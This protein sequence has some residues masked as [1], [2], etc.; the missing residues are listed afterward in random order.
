MLHCIITHKNSHIVVANH[1]YNI[2]EVKTLGKVALCMLYN[3][4]YALY[5]LLA[6]L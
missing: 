6:T 3:S 2:S 5:S 4:T 1:L